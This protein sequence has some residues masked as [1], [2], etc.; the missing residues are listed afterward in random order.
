MLTFMNFAD[1]LKK[2]RAEKGLTQN[3]LAKAIG[4]GQSA[5]G[6]LEAGLRQPSL[7]MIKA[8]ASYFQIS[9]SVLIDA[10]ETKE[11]SA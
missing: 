9:T 11:L 2:L 10:T 7:W 1:L 6:N 8:L 3:Q 4:V 5:I